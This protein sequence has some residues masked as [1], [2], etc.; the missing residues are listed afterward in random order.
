MARLY[1]MKLK[2]DF[3]KRHDIQVIEAMPNGK[4][5][6]LFY[7]KLLCESLDHEGN[8]RFSDTIPYNEDML[9]AITHTNIDIV[10]SAM[11]LLIQLG[12][13]EIF[14]DKTIYMSEVEKFI[15]SESDSAERVRKHRALKAPETGKALP[16][17]AD[18]TKC[19]A[20][21]TQACY[22][23]KRKEAKE[24]KSIEYRVKSL[25]VSKYES[26]ER[27]NEDIHT[28]AGA[29][30]RESYEDI[31]NDCMVSETVRPVVWEFIKHCQLNGRT[32][33]NEKL[34]GILVEMDMRSYDDQAK[35]DALNAA[36]SGGYYDIKR[37]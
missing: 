22:I 26:K 25:D 11:N 29:C 37:T 7:L 21:V 28:S 8:L 27:N 9:S 34:S 10:R 24:K 20:D 35:I 17:N 12:L 23:D 30:A 19:N 16:R 36:I 31:M 18:V 2:K 4:D 6:V 14:D 5:Y 13:V 33:T 32:L 1:W 3:F 15:G